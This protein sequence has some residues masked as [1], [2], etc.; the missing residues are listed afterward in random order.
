[1]EHKRGLLHIGFSSMLSGEKMS[2]LSLGRANRMWRGE[3]AVAAKGSPEI[4]TCNVRQHYKCG[5]LQ[6]NPWYPLTARES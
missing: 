5:E 6:A 1:M 3:Q 2:Q 4:R